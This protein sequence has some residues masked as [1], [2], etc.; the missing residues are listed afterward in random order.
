MSAEREPDAA[1][2]DYERVV[3]S[4]AT[5]IDETGLTE[6]EIEQGG[7]RVRV[8]RHQATVVASAPAGIAAGSTPTSVARASVEFFISD[9]LF[10]PAARIPVND[11]TGP[12]GVGPGSG[13][14][15]S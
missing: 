8:A 5:L 4:L 1:G 9:I 2:T 12:A 7:L 10:G 13:G 15:G 6:I 3:R 14:C 11:K